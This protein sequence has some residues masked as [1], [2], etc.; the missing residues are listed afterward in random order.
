MSSSGLVPLPS[1][2]R[3]ENEYGPSKA[4]LA[5][6]T[7]PLP[8][9]KAPSHV[10]SALRVGIARPNLSRKRS[11]FGT[12]RFLEWSHFLF[13]CTQ[14]KPNILVPLLALLYTLRSE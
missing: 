4:P 10:A 7:V 8:S 14:F 11:L 13:H 1:S 12:N 9:F 6:F 2:K 5:S 3:D